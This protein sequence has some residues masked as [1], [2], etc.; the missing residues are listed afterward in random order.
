MGFNPYWDF[1]PNITFSNDNSPR[2]LA[3]DEVK[4]RYEF[5][6][7]CFV[8]VFIKPILFTSALDEPPGVE[9]FC[10]HEI[11]LEINESK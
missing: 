2:K 11:N 10:E 5:Y 9:V 4:K 6:E 3:F 7:G 1:T 8:K